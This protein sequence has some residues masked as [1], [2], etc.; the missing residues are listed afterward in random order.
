MGCR[1]N[2]RQ[3]RSE[4]LYRHVQTEWVDSPSR[5]SHEIVKTWRSKRRWRP[6]FW[7]ERNNEM[8]GRFTG[9]LV[10]VAGGTGALGRAVTLSFLDES[11]NVVVTYRREQE[12]AAL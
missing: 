10:L 9:K 4:R 3:P 12:F 11:A 1:R 5:L 8:V 2:R 7:Q 6:N